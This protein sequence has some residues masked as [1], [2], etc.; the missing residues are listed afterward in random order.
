MTKLNEDFLIKVSEIGKGSFLR[1][2]NNESI[3]EPIVNIVS[4]GEES[5]INSYEF[6]DYD[7]KYKYTLFF[8][9]LF[10]FV[11]YILPTGNRR[12]WRYYL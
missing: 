1:V 8:A 3:S 2:S 12:I 7:Y 5:L 10:L 4:T 11:S 6:S 9:I